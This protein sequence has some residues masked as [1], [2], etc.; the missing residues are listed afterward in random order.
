MDLI[1]TE[2][3][4]HPH[5][6]SP[7]VEGGKNKMIALYDSRPRQLA[8]HGQRCPLSFNFS[9][10]LQDVTAH[11]SNNRPTVWNLLKHSALPE[12]HIYHYREMVSPLE[13]NRI[14]RENIKLKSSERT[15]TCERDKYK[16]EVF[17]L[18]ERVR[19]GDQR[20]RI[21]G[22]VPPD[23]LGK[24]TAPRPPAALLRGR[25]AINKKEAQKW[26]DSDY[27]DLPSPQPDPVNEPVNQPH[28]NAGQPSLTAPLPITNTANS[29]ENSN[30]LVEVSIIPPPTHLLSQSFMLF[31]LIYNYFFLG[32]G[33]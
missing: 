12:T 13:F 8:I 10:L 7:I 17:D 30:H 2:H 19:I 11:N 25:A 15:L 4:L 33:R 5:I 27:Q 31:N 6:Q 22:D 14:M 28:P 21:A 16:R 32:V 24:G 9:H 18:S 20:L 3:P 26:H 1:G 29:D 23:L